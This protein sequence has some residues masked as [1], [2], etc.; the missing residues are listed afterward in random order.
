MMSIIGDEINLLEIGEKKNEKEKK[1][2]KRA[3]ILS[4]IGLRECFYK[5]SAG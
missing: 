1:N 2:R 3:V 5:K 4:E